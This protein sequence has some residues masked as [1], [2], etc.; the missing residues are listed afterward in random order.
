MERLMACL[1]HLMLD[2]DGPE[3]RLNFIINKHK[4]DREVMERIWMF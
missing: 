1:S 2:I 3:M 4:D